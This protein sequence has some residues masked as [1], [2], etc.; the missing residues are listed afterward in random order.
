LDA[1]LANKELTAAVEKLSRVYALNPV[2]PADEV[3][4]QA[5]RE[6]Y[7]DLCVEEYKAALALSRQPARRFDAVERLRAIESQLKSLSEIPL[8]PAAAALHEKEKQCLEL[9]AQLAQQ[10]AS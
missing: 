1:A 3:A 9:V 7:A 10:L 8:P 2:A 6:K 4:R 5:R